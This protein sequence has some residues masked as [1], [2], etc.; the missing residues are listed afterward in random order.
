[1]ES[2]KRNPNINW[3][4]YGDLLLEK[5]MPKNIQF[6]RATLDDFNILTSQKLGIR[7]KLNNPYKLCDFRP[8]FAIIFSEYISTYDYWGYCDLDLIFGNILSIL[9][10][11][12]Y[13]NYDIITTREDS[14]AGHFT[15]FRNRPLINHMY[16]KIWRYNLH[17]LN[18]NKHFYLDERSN[19]IG[20]QYKKEF[21]RFN[22]WDFLK[23]IRNS[24]SYRTLKVLPLLYD[25][26]RV[27][28]RLEKQG[29]IK[30]LRIPKIQSDENFRREQIKDW[31]I[32]WKEGALKDL[33]HNEELLYFHFIQLK[34]SKDF[35][36][37]PLRDT[38][39]F[40]ITQ[41]GIQC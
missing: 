17:L 16:S 24:L 31:K 20:Q 26:T 39:T 40:E 25:I 18:I 4:L 12:N 34:K 37:Y 7:V 13:T 2:C 11:N 5:E 8:S 29:S 41:K 23:K 14:L 22:F 38:P 6:I 32:I 35:I 36:T 21:R 3:L 10:Q 27:A 19:Y 28:Y 1:M 9:T 30:I 15:I 33:H